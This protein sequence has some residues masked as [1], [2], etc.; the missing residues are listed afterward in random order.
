MAF[1]AGTVNSFGAAANDLF[2]AEGHRAKAQGLRLEAQNY[3][4]ASE[5]AL[6]N[7]KFTEVSTAIKQAQTDRDIYTP[8]AGS[9][10]TSPARA[11]RHPAAR[12]TSC[13]TA[14]RR[15]RW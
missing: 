7:E 9:R 2:S 15:A 5:Y 12:S 6:K 8:S 11:L 1:G 13:G 10:R 4:L 3:D 14:P